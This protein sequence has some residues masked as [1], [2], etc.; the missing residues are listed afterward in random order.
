M[1]EQHFRVYVHNVIN[2][3]RTNEKL[4]KVIKLVFSKWCITNT[5]TIHISQLNV[6]DKCINTVS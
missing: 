6:K 2:T 1:P 3:S 5:Y 4:L